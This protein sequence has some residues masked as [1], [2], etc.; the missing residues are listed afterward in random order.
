LG[1]GKTVK[2]M[3]QLTSSSF[4]PLAASKQQQV[5]YHAR[6]FDIT[7]AWVTVPFKNGRS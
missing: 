1:E 7:A 3:G 6:L 4:G 2:K 5:I